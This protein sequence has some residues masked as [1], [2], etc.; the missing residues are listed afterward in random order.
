MNKRIVGASKVAGTEIG[1]AE[2]VKRLAS[3]GC[4]PTAFFRSRMAAEYSFFSIRALPLA[5]N[6]AP[7]CCGV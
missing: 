4:I 1:Q 6:L 3:S 5:R 7:C 2:L